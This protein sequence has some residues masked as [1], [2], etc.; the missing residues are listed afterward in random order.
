MQGTRSWSARS[1]VTT[2]TFPSKA[3]HGGGQTEVFDLR[4][5]TGTPS[6]Y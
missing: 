4:S 6:I 5:A 2:S 3:R 1:C